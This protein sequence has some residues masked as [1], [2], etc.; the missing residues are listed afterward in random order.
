[1]PSRAQIPISG[2][3]GADGT[4]YIWSQ[5]FTQWSIVNVFAQV[6]EGT[7][8]WTIY[9]SATNVPGAGTPLGDA[10]GGSV[11]QSG[12]IMA[13][14][15]FILVQVTGATAGAQVLGT[16]FGV[17]NVDLTDLPAVPSSPASG[18]Q[19]SGTV[20][21]EIT[22]G[23]VGI[24]GNVPVYNAS[25][26]VLESRP[27]YTT[28]T[29][30][31]TITYL[32]STVPVDHT[33]GFAIGDFLAIVPDSASIYWPPPQVLVIGVPS[34]TSLS[35]ILIGSQAYTS[36]SVTAG[37][38]LNS[39]PGASV[40]NSPDA[41]LY[42]QGANWLLGQISNVAP[43]TSSTQTFYETTN[44]TLGLMLILIGS[45][46]GDGAVITITGRTGGTSYG[47][48]DIVVGQYAQAPFAGTIEESGCNIT[49]AANSGNT[50]DVTVVIQAVGS[51]VQPYNVL[52]PPQAWEAPSKIYNFFGSAPTSA[53]AVVT[54][55]A[56]KQIYIFSVYGVNQGGEGYFTCSSGQLTPNVT[57]TGA[58]FSGN[59]NG[60]ALGVG[61]ALE[62][63]GNNT[64]SVSL[65]CTYSI[66]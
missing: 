54:P 41:P 4:C 5:R 14:N 64:G 32:A 8:G 27:T 23:S 3:V 57:T 28:V 45:Q 61:N 63:T 48:A 33:Y 25:E 21:A 46:A 47:V 53:T 12:I 6:S 2:T 36:V 50:S 24:S 31:A 56:G 9:S 29:G 49:V 18:T 62:I 15:E 43:G 35:V 20:Q 11:Q 39:F 1:M 58:T 59:L 30:S 26:T 7:C 60:F 13:P 55:P 40:I 44:G 52:V 19:L 38:V 10:V 34:S 65:G 22:G 66:N 16:I 51:A 37:T 42:T 17:Q